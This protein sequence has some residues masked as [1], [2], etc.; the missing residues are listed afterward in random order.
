MPFMSFVSDLF[1][2]F[3][4]YPIFN[5]LMSLYQLFGDMGLAIVVLTVFFFMLLFPFAMKRLRAQ[6]AAQLLQA[7]LSEEL[8]ALGAKYANDPMAL[9]AAKQELYKQHGVKSPTLGASMFVQMFLFS[10]LFFALNSVLRNATITSINR[11]M[12]PFLM[13]FSSL[14]NLQLTWFAIF[15]GAWHISLATADPSHIL[16]ILT[17]IMTFIQMRMAQPLP[18]AQAKEAM[19]HSAQLMQIL[20]PLLMV[21]V[22]IFF[23]WQFAAGIALYRLVWIGLNMVQQF[24]VSGWGSLWSVPRLAHMQAAGAPMPLQQ[25]MKQDDIS[26]SASRFTHKAKKSHRRHHPR[27]Y[28]K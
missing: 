23:A 1:N 16:P 4:T 25:V 11:I 6:H 14:P 15:E 28:R 26:P 19:T 20:L 5:I 9:L 24:F 17:G 12:Y 22:T 8:A 13:H 18:L 3:F 10:G 2:T 7:S 27:R 21:G